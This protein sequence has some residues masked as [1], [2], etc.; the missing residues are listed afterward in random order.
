MRTSIE[1]QYNPHPGE[2]LYDILQSIDMSQ[3]EL[4]EKLEMTPKH[5]NQFIQGKT[6]LTNDMAC[7]LELV[8]G[9]SAQTWMNLEFNYQS[10]KTRAEL[11]AQKEEELKLVS[12]YPYSWLEK[13]KLVPKTKNKNERLE[14]L[15]TFFQTLSLKNHTQQTFSHIAFKAKPSFSKE[16]FLTWLQVGDTLAQNEVVEKKHTKKDIIQVFNNIKNR[17]DKNPVITLRK[18]K[19][20]FKKIGITI[21]FIPYIEKCGIRG[22]TKKIKGNPVIYLSD[23][24]KKIDSI[25]FTLAHEL[26][27]IANNH[28]MKK[29]FISLESDNLSTTDLEKEADIFAQDIILSKNS[30]LEYQSKILFNIAEQIEEIESLSRK[31]SARVDLIIG[32]LSYDKHIEWKNFNKYRQSVS[33]TTPF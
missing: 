19:D 33:F 16:S 24:G 8:L 2:F 29:P 22:V 9:T 26:G 12:K 30:Y 17:Y 15:F 21:I 25:L 32:R 4:A 18:I 14:N 1:S 31:E 7:R 3:K 27:H 11:L 10:Q 5:I 23:H 6:S 20:E 28:P 13:N